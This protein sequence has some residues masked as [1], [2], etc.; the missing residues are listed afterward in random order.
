MSLILE[1]DGLVG[2]ENDSLVGLENDG[3]V[4]LQNDGLVD[5]INEYYNDHD[6]KNDGLVDDKNEYYDDPGG[7][8]AIDE[9]NYNHDGLVDLNND[10]DGLV[11]LDNDND[12]LVDPKNNNDYLVSLNR[13]GLVG[14]VCLIGDGG[15]STSHSVCRLIDNFDGDS[16]SGSVGSLERCIHKIYTSLSSWSQEFCNFLSEFAKNIKERETIY[17]VQ[18]LCPNREKSLA[19]GE[20][21]LE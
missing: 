20:R 10:N 9:D 17:W 5:E 14:F 11:D 7:L 19:L 8:M 21:G 13:D 2:L 4:G 18:G 12:C 1:N 15:G 3:L 16:V 6:L